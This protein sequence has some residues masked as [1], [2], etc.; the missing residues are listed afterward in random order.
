MTYARS[1]TVNSLYCN[2]LDEGYKL[3]SFELTSLFTNIPLRKTVN[4]ILKRIYNSNLVSTTLL[5]RMKKFILD[6]CTKTVFS[7]NGQL[8]KQIDGVSMGSPLSP[9]LVNAIVTEFENLVIRPLITSGHIKFYKRYVDD[10]LIL[11]KPRDMENILTA[12]NSFQPENKFTIDQF[13]DNNI[14]FLDIQ[15]HPCGTTV[16]RKSTHT[17]QYQR[18]TIFSPWLRK[19]AWIQALANRA[20]IYLSV[21]WTS[22]HGMV[23]RI[24]YR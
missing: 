16:Y 1:A 18:I 8:Y 20:Y 9:T 10:T 2:L 17:G 22:C 23:F 5:K 6:S 14:H 24:N 19:V 7:I 13:S 4:I 3:V 11:A 12:F 21:S 15:I